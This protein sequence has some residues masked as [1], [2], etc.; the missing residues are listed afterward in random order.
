MRYAFFIT[1]FLLLQLFSVGM[2]LSLQWWLQPWSTPAL[3]I[4]V[5]VSVFAIT[6]I[7]LILSVKRALC[8]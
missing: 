1:I 4:A 2:A 3:E 8:Q 6:N 7:L 5:W